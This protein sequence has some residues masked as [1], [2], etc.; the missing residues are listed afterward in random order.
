[1]KR[2]APSGREI[3]AALHLPTPSP[4]NLGVQKSVIRTDNLILKGKGVATFVDSQEKSNL[5]KPELC[6]FR[7]GQ[8]IYLPPQRYIFSVK[9][10]VCFLAAAQPHIPISGTLQYLNNVK[11]IFYA[12]SQSCSIF[13]AMS[14]TFHLNF[15]CA[16]LQFFPFSN[17]ALNLEQ[18][19]SLLRLD[20]SASIYKSSFVCHFWPKGLGLNLELVI[21]FCQVAE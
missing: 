5:R 19:R 17:P 7:G 8:L 4:T 1:M 20:F 18:Q 2:A 3:N 15:V 6:L 10:L 14:F 9:F 11:A 16:L 12:R 21:N 13:L